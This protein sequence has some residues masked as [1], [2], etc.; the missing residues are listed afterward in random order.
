MI[1]RNESKKE[2]INRLL[3][4]RE[5]R[6]WWHGAMLCLASLVVFGTVYTLILPAVTLEEQPLCSLEE[7]VHYVV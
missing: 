1:E 2:S 6:K 3:G 5:Q 7:H 4:A